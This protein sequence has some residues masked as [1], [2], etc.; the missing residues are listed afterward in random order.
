MTAYTLPP[1]M[2]LGRANAPF[3]QTISQDDLGELSRA[4]LEGLSR[5]PLGISA[6]LVAMRNGQV[7]ERDGMEAIVRSQSQKRA[8]VRRFLI[9]VFNGIFD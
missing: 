6:I 7:S 8:R 4:D 2:Q 1:N 3:V 9:G 5:E